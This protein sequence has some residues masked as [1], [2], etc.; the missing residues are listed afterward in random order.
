VSGGIVVDYEEL[1]RLARVWAAA[2]DTLG[3]L[4]FRVADVTVSPAVFESAL[5]DPGGVARAQVAIT[6]AVLALARLA[7]ELATDAVHLD[8]VVAREQLVDDLPA[9]Q[10]AALGSWLVAANWRVAFSPGAT[11]HEGG[12]R[13]LALAGGVVGYATPFTEPLLEAFA[14]SPLFRLEAHGHQRVDVDPVFGL[15]IGAVGRLEPQGEGRVEVAGYLPSWASR[16]PSS[17]ADAMARVADLEAQPVALLAVQAVTGAD[18][19]R[20]F[21]VELPGIRSLASRQQPQ[22]LLGAVDA[23][24]GDSSTYTRCVREALDSAGVPLGAQVMLV[25]HSDG[26]IVAMDLAH[27]PSFNGARVDVT[28]VVAA[29]SPISSKLAA[30]GSSPTRVLSVENVNDIVTHLDGIDSMDQPETARRLSYQ[31]SDDEHDIGA[32]HAGAEYADRMAVLADS[33]NPLMREFQA[34]AQPYLPTAADTATTTVFALTD[35]PS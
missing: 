1:H 34:S 21:V 17:L 6:T 11:L 20:R 13:A 29:G 10:L 32:N 26:G 15:P 33:P 9:G 23:L 25:G 4:A 16:A 3:R 30:L 5:F 18:G 8:A 28:H 19:V 7:A 35:A 14:P 22:D 2:A 27:D 24:A 12:D 31:Y